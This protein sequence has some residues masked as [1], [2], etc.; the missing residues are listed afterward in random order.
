MVIQL[1]DERHP[2]GNIELYDISLADVVQI[3][4]QRAQAVAVR[5]DDYALA[6]LDGRSDGFVPQRQ[7]AR[8]RVLEALGERQFLLAEALVARVVAGETRIVH[9]QFGRWNIVAAAPDFDL[10][11]A[12]FG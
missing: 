10:L 1:V 7:K 5:G 4:H 9:R 11:L 12:E 2:R 3:L 6:V 8:H